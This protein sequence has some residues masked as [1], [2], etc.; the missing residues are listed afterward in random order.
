M[1]EA[2]RVYL[3]GA[4]P[5]DPGLVTLR[6]AELLARADLVLYDQLVPRRVLDLARPGAEC[7]GVRDLPGVGG[8]RTPLLARLIEAAEAGRLVV[9]LKAGDPLTFGR[10]G[11][12]AEGL[13]A[14]GV[15]YEI[16]PGVTAA[17]AAAAYLE[18]PLARRTGQSRGALALVTGHDLPA[19]PGQGLDWQALARFPGALS[20]YMGLS[21]LPLIAAELLKFGR[22]PATPAGVVER[23]STGE[24]RSVFAPL[25][26]IDQ[27]RRH[28][29]LEAP[30][31][32][33]V[34]ESLAHRPAKG[35]YES[36]PLFGTRV[37][38]C[39]PAAQAE[40][41]MRDLERL[42]AVASR[43]STL[44]IR[45]PADW[46]PVDAAIQS[47]RQAA[48]S[49]WVA[50]TSANGV[51]GL[52][53]RVRELGFDARA[54]GPAQLAAVGPKTAEALAEFNLK[55]DHVPPGPFDADSLADGLAELVRGK[56]LLFARANRGKETLITRL[57]T[58]ARVSAV[59]VY[60]QVDA[61]IDPDSPVLAALRRG[62]VGLVL[63]GSANAGKALAAA[64]DDTL[65][66]RVERGE[67]RLIA[68][69]SSVAGVLAGLGYPAVAADEAT[70]AGLVAK[71]VEVVT[72]RPEAR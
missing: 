31:L 71:A 33:L 13:R 45:P 18:L 15:R 37:L 40:E 63:V 41:T 46:G 68:I 24:M 17:L 59:A 6:A 12:E 65:R 67:L 50:F 26:E 22:D 10:G 60:E 2:A 3:V 70:G 57:S 62:E 69:S 61:A 56:R 39:R 64:F 1:S 27:A 30:G 54:F 14:A 34:G 32:I 43:L 35:W 5:G 72:S 23:A 52:C 20:I 42:G 51:R 4:G 21:R 16:V 58:V 53:G 48:A 66:G 44:E 47:L 8:A 36:L 9:R 28:A 49:D 19:K 11:E 55:A 38:V 29:G 7:V 25:G